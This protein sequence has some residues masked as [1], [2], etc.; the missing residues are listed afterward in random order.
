MLEHKLQHF[1]SALYYGGSGPGAATE[2]YNGTSWTNSTNMTAP[3]NR[4][5]ASTNGTTT[6]AFAAG[7]PGTSTLEYVGPNPATKT[8]GTI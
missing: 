8:V 7:G 4:A 6:A 5:G 2:E 1:L 3:K